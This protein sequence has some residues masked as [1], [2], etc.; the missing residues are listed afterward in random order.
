MAEL[1]AG[2]A[3]VTATRQHHSFGGSEDATLLMSE[4]HRRGGQA[5]Y[6][7]LGSDLRAGHHNERFDFDERS[8]TIGAELLGRLLVYFLGTPER[9]GVVN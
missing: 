2:I 1:G 8:L 3:G 4:I 7:M 6:V 5:T 9:N